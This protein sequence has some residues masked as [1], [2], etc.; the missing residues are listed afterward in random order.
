M[1]LEDFWLGQKLVSTAVTLGAEDLVAFASVTGDRHPMHLPGLGRPD[2]EVVGHGPWGLARYF[3]T[4]WEDG[5][6]ED[7]VIGLLQSDWRY[8]A[9]LRIGATY[10]WH[11]VVTGWRRSSTDP[12]RG[13]LHRDVQMIDAGGQVVQAGTLVA[14]VEAARPDGADDPA[15]ALPLSADWA[16]AVVT[17]LEDSVEFYD[18]TQTFDGA[19]GLESPAASIQLRVYKG[20]VIDV[21]RRTPGGADF[22]LVGSAR[23]WCDLMTASRND[24]VVRTSNGEF[25]VVGN[26]YVYLQL[27]RALHLVVDAGRTI[28]EGASR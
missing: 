9:P 20:R 15:C 27:T 25:S 3:G 2:A 4:V 6:L 19:I 14:L 18:T 22:T 11:T 28:T 12:T 5:S 13:I 21:A 17:R 16:R 10:T 8:V 26:A 7:S 23:A 24:F 1:H